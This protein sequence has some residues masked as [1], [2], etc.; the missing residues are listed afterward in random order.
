M[1]KNVIEEYNKI[2]LLLNE[3]NISFMNH[4]YF[5]SYA[6]ILEEDFLFKNQISLYLKLFEGIDVAGKKILEVGCG[7]GG[8]IASVLKYLKAE[9]LFACDINEL[10]IEYCKES[11]DKKISFKVS[12]AQ[13]L[14]YDDNM[15]DILLSVESSHCYDFPNHFFDEVSR[16]LKP[17]GVF[18][19]TDCGK[20][21]KTFESRSSY[22][23]N[24]KKENITNNVKQ[25]CEED[26]DKWKRL[27]LNEQVR[28]KFAG[29]AIEKSAEY[30]EGSDMYIIYV[31]E[32]H[33]KDEPVKV[34]GDINEQV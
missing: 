4:G 11:H 8:G 14:D 34:L 33:N 20:N 17:G 7:R 13:S 3:S 12:D 26:H 22:F 29:I 6:G 28:D 2:N 5:P 16:V 9:E 10:N 31:A 32:N 18:L 1:N 25:S 19:Y 30:S 15:F 23:K 27:I 21:I 24:I